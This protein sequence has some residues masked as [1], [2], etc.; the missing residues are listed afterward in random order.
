M[1]RGERDTKEYGKM[2]LVYSLTFILLLFGCSHNKV[3]RLDSKNMQLTTIRW[4]ANDLQEMSQEMVLSLLSS[5]I[6]FS[7]N[8]V[9]AFG[10]IRNDT[11]DHIDTKLLAN[12][13][14]VG[15]TKSGKMS[16][17]E[18]LQSKVSKLGKKQIDLV[19]GY[20]VDRIFYG[21]MSSF[22][23]KNSEGKDMHFEFELWLTDVESRKI[24]WSNKFEI[25][26]EY[27]KELIGW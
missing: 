22:F 16:F 2:K 19:K 9:Y 23:K 11:Y 1:D 25:R 27:K 17:S 20:G 21:K 18:N 15:L 10:K 3:N 14:M 26:K 12:K 24:L 13:T 7:K 4:G 5:N 6:D 8:K